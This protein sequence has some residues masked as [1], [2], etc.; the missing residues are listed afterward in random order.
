M[1]TIRAIVFAYFPSFLMFPYLWNKRCADALCETYW[2]R[3][4]GR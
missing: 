3:N 4:A 1:K 2:R